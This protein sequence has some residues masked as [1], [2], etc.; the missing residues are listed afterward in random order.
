MIKAGSRLR[1]DTLAIHGGQEA[2]P[3]TG[4]MAVPIYQTASY[5]FRDTGHAARLFAL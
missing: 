1:I 5:R 2:D 3:A 4:S